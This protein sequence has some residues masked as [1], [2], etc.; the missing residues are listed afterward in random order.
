MLVLG[1]RTDPR[2]TDELCWRTPLW[3]LGRDCGCVL[4]TLPRAVAAGLFWRASSFRLF[5]SLFVLPDFVRLLL[6]IVLLFVVRPFSI[7]LLLSLFRV[8][9]G[10]TVE[11]RPD[12]E[13]L[14]AASGRY[15]LT[16]L[17]VTLVE[18]LPERLLVVWMVRTDVRLPVSRS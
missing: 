18:V 13:P 7:F 8:V 3:L 9:A 16:E 17:L 10:R 15:T 5:T 14:V 11:V 6:S 2:C 1:W 12:D 4:F